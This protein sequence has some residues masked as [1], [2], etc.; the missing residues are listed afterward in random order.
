[1][2]LTMES[3]LPYI[4]AFAAVIMAVVFGFRSW[5]LSKRERRSRQLRR[6]GSRQS[7]QFSRHSRH[8]S[9]SR[10][11]RRGVRGSDYPRG[12]SSRGEFRGDSSSPAGSEDSSSPR[13]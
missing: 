8:F 7:R 2:N 6:S 10:P 3:I 11:S 12:R 9:S 1:M 13:L 5:M 4:L